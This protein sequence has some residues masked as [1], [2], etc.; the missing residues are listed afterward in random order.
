MMKFERCN[1]K[2]EKWVNLQERL[3]FGFGIVKRERESREERCMHTFQCVN[4]TNTVL[5]WSLRE[6]NTP[7]TMENENTPFDFSF[8]HFEQLYHLFIF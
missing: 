6:Q 2:K 3:E 8:L 4:S 7:T 1:E 5:N